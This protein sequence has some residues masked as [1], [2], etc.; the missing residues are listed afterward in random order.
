MTE[1]TRGIAVAGDGKSATKLVDRGG[2]VHGRC[3]STK[4]GVSDACALEILTFP[5]G[6]A[7]IGDRLRTGIRSTEKLFHTIVE[8]LRSDGVGR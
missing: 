7:G 1:R 4:S 2:Q 5:Y 6:G 3:R 8:E